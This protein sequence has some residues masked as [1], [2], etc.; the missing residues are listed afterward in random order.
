MGNSYPWFDWRCC[1][2]PL[3]HRF[4][5]Y[6]RQYPGI[7]SPWHTWTVSFLQCFRSKLFTVFSQVATHIPFAFMRLLNIHLIKSVFHGFCTVSATTVVAVLVAVMVPAVAHFVIQLGFQSIFQNVAH[8]FLNKALMADI[9]L[10]SGSFISSRTLALRSVS[11]EIHVQC[12]I[13]I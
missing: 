3:S 6:A 2:I 8:N 12:T 4:L 13:F 1:L 9:L 10:T 11:S 5:K 7:S